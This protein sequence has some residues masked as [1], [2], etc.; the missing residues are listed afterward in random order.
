M[1]NEDTELASHF[2]IGDYRALRTDLNTDSCIEAWD[3]LLKAVARRID[4]RFLEPIKQLERFDDED[5]LP[6]RPGFSILAIDCLLIDTIQ[7]FRKGRVRTGEGSPAHSFKTFL[8]SPPF[9]DDFKSDD[10]SDFFDNVRNAIFH[11]GETRKDWKIRIDTSL[12]LEKNPAKH[13]KT[14]NRRLFH[15]AVVIEWHQFLGDVRS[16]KGDSR[17]LFL[18]RMDALAGLPVEP[19]P[20]L[21]FAYGSNLLESEC[22]RTAP[23]AKYYCNAFVPG[24]AIEFTKHSVTRSGDAATIVKDPNRVTWGS[25]YRVHQADKTKLEIRERGYSLTPDLSVYLV[26]S[27]PKELPSPVSAFTFMAIDKCQGG[28]GPQSDYLDLIKQGAH[29]R[30]LPIEYQQMLASVGKPIGNEAA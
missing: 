20:F 12:M 11:N 13:T 4:E 17:E 22:L 19:L 10:R 3:K 6:F 27:D 30:G 15:Q 21:Y 1:L 16:G 25:V 5:D 7:S 8:K 9:A 24:Y 14:V 29:C 26:S 28:C 2:T 18:R 23:G